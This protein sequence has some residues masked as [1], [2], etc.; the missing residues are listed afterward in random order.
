VNIA[1]TDAQ[2]SRMI[3]AELLDEKSGTIDSTLTTSAALSESARKS[4][5]QSGDVQAVYDALSKRQDLEAASARIQASQAI[6]KVEKSGAWPRVVLVGHAGYRS[7]DG[8]SFR[9]E[10][11]DVYGGIRVEWDIFDGNLRRNRVREA[12]S[13]EAEAGQILV[14]KT[15]EVRRDVLVSRAEARSSLAILEARQKAVASAEQ[16]RNM[17]RDRFDAGMSTMT[18]VMFAEQLLLNEKA[19][20]AGAQIQALTAYEVASA[21]AATNMPE[22]RAAAKAPEKKKENK[23]KR[24]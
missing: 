19:R 10:N 15:A 18:E 12:Q 11:Q 5:E 6:V 14:A 4:L 3:L 21:S 20:L 23:P 16:K 17:A 24:N 2:I 9:E 1:K 22:L 7:A 8:Y 13:V